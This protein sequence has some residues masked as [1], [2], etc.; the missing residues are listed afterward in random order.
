MILWKRTVVVESPVPAMGMLRLPP[1]RKRRLQGSAAGAFGWAVNE[2]PHL[3]YHS[4]IFHSSL[5]KLSCPGLNTVLGA[6]V[7]SR[8]RLVSFPARR[9]IP[10]L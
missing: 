1:S 9:R 2:D 10:P 6:V 5:A 7:R 4:T 3:E 8:S